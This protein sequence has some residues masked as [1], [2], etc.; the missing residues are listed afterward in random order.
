MGKTFVMVKYVHS[1]IEYEFSDD[2]D[3]DD[4][5]TV[6]KSS[7]EEKILKITETQENHDGFN[8]ISKSKFE[9]W[10]ENKIYRIAYDTEHFILF[11]YKYLN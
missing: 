6:L 3:D 5:R 4:E 9:K 10:I 2:Q 1:R 7:R 8:H 11:D